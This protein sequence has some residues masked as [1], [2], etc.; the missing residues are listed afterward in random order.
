MIQSFIMMP[1]MG[2]KGPQPPGPQGP[3]PP[4]PQQGAN[5][6]QMRST[7]IDVLTKVKQVAEKN[8][9]SFTELVAQVGKSGGG[10]P[11]APSRPS[12]PLPPP[13]AG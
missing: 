12:S 8:G 6:Q 3:M 5:P 7:L 1:M 4:A 13:Q 9:I 2:P 11:P 10:A